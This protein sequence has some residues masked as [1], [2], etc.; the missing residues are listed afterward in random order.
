MR[1]VFSIRPLANRRQA[2]GP[3]AIA[4]SLAAVLLLSPAT[5]GAWTLSLAD[6][7]V[8]PP[9]AVK[10][11]DV[12]TG[13]VPVAASGLLLTS[14]AHPG[15][16]FTVSRNGLLRKLVGERMAAG[17]RCEGA[18][19]CLVVVAGSRI[20]E[21]TLRERLG[22]ALHRW[23]PT[24]APGAPPVWSEILG[25][26]PTPPVAEA[27]RVSLVEPKTL[28]PGRNLVRVAV[29]AGGR[30]SRFTATVVCHV[31]AETAS[32]VGVVE[33][34]DPLRPGLFAWEWADLARID[35]GAARGRDSLTG[36]AA[37]RRLAAGDVLRRSD[38][39]P[40]PLVRRG[41]PVELVL[42]RGGVA[43]SVTGR[44]R[45]DGA[46]DQIITVRSDVDGR[47][48]TGRVAADGRIMWRR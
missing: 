8:V 15:Q 33:A 2:A 6:S 43:V 25:E 44:A 10:L 35:A 36:M 34:G 14:D 3:V 46:R 13:A 31:F 32:A 20:A 47:L 9:G 29:D 27:W 22:L 30:R 7:V 39:E 42:A 19:S 45:Q 40:I 11:G 18:E 41:E 24:A 12:L 48:V 16:R 1:R 26:L 28:E 17:V 21:A 38:L 4:C 5:V 23:L 37:G